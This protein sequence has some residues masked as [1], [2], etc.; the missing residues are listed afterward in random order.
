MRICVG[1][2][3]V[4]TNETELA[5]ATVTFCWYSFIFL[6][7]V[8]SAFES[9]ALQTV[10]GFKVRGVSKVSIAGRC[11]C[12][13]KWSSRFSRIETWARLR[14]S[15]ATSNMANNKALQGHIAVTV[16]THPRYILTEATF[17]YRTYSSSESPH[18]KY[19]EALERLLNL[20]VAASKSEECANYK[21]LYV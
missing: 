8:S 20:G 10:S 1:D 21:N 6:P 18:P 15:P 5:K 17:P 14:L 19:P 2:K 3:T 16:L 4:A 11:N 13:S 7:V 12:A 9:V